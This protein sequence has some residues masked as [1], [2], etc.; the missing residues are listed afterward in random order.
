MNIN[1]IFYIKDFV[2]AKIT[3]ENNNKNTPLYVEEFKNNIRTKTNKQFIEI[4]LSTFIPDI[5]SNNGKKEK[6]YTK[7]VEIVVGEWWYRFSGSEYNAPTTKSGTE[8][9]EIIFKNNSIVSDAKSFRLGRSQKA[10]NVKDFLKLASMKTWMQNLK[11]KYEAKNIEQEILGGLVTYSSLHEWEGESEVYEE[12]SNN[13]IP[14][15][16][17]PYEI[18]ALLLE[19]NDNCTPENFLTL[20]NYEQFFPQTTRSKHEYWTTINCAIRTILNMD[21]KTYDCKIKEYRENIMYIVEQFK[22]QIN[23]DIENKKIELRNHLDQF[24]SIEELR[25]YVFKIIEQERNRENQE[26]LNRI[27]NFRKYCNNN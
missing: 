13:G 16:M 24:N 25:E 2:D 4:L 5:Y 12:C 22:E 8:D 18:L 27:N 20:W 3:E 9:I 23:R 19:Y 11:K 21:I 14:V 7:L 1:N 6:L 10:P 26:Y 15:V 17:L